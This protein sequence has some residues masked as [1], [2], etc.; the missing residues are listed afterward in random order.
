MAKKSENKGKKQQQDERDFASEGTDSGSAI[1]STPDP[2]YDLISVLYHALQAEETC[3]KYRSDVEDGD[4]EL[5]EFFSEACA[6]YSEISERAKEL[7]ARRIGASGSMRAP[8]R[9]AGIEAGDSD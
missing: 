4:E 8:S 6:Q 7:L 1:T 2:T 3:E 5:E 9:E